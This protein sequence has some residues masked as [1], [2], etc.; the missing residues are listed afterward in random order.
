MAFL[1]DPKILLSHL[2]HSFIT[3]DDTGISELVMITEDLEKEIN[4]EQSFHKRASRLSRKLQHSTVSLFAAK[5]LDIS[6]SPTLSGRPRE[7][8]VAFNV[9]RDNRL[10]TIGEKKCK[11]ITWKDLST[12]QVDMSVFERQDI[13][14]PDKVPSPLTL[15]LQ[16]EEVMRT[17]PYYSYS[18]HNGEGH[19]GAVATSKF[20]IFFAIGEE[21]MEPLKVC[22]LNSATVQDLIGLSFWKYNEGRKEP[23]KFKK[24]ARYTVRIA[25]DDGDIDTDLPELRSEEKIGKFGFTSLGIVEKNMPPSPGAEHKTK[26]HPT[27]MA[28]KVYFDQGGFSTIAVKDPKM[29][30]LEIFDKVIKRRQLHKGPLTDFQ[31]EKKDLPGIP[32]DLSQSLDVQDSDEFLLTRIHTGK[33][34]PVS[35]SSTD[36]VDGSP[37]PFSR[38]GKF[39]SSVRAELTS[40]Q[41]KS[42]SVTQVHKVRSNVPVQ[43]AISSKWIEVNPEGGSTK[44]ALKFL[45]HNPKRSSYNMEQ[46][47]D[48]ELVDERGHKVQFRLVRKAKDGTFKST[49]FEASPKDAKEIIG[50]IKHILETQVSAVRREYLEQEDKSR[51]NSKSS[52]TSQ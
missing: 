19:Q 36:D 47:C 22:I 10:D 15:L 17:N 2:R 41:F 45:K 25:E 23:V 29:K 6:T 16:Q 8:G 9:Q 49:L 32:V 26:Q 18:R 13:K 39:Q 11:K 52:V 7:R 5:S 37:S 34:P 24:I 30:M 43:L 50:K 1:D 27:Q 31:L 28:V 4:N 3:S 14:K 35:P 12:S 33:S 46:I 20:N 48:C 21:N 38:H 42:F 51:R 40:Y 44:S